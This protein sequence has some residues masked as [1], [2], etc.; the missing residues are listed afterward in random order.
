MEMT[1]TGTGAPKRQVWNAGRTVGAKLALN[2]RD[3]HAAE[4][5]KA[6]SI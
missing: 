3:C 4:D 2:P 1:E 6:C 5:G